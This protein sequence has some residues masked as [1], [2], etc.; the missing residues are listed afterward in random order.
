VIITFFSS[1]KAI[2]IAIEA[3]TEK[4]TGVINSTV[5]PFLPSALIVTALPHCAHDRHSTLVMLC[6]YKTSSGREERDRG[7]DDRSRFLSRLGLC[8]RADV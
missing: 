2:A 1:C 6:R 7:H 5:F 3:A 8:D 4:L